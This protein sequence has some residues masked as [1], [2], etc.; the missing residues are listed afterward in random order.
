MLRKKKVDIPEKMLHNFSDLFEHGQTY[1]T[2]QNENEIF[3]MLSVK[4]QFMLAL[5][6]CAGGGLCIKWG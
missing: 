3:V 4:R 6:V 2:R 1:Q 5:C